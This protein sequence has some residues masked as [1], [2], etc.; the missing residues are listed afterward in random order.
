MSGN[1]ESRSDAPSILRARGVVLYPDR[2]PTIRTT[3]E[4]WREIEVSESEYLALLRQGLIFDGTPP[5]PPPPSFSDEQYDELDDPESEAASRLV[6]AVLD[7]LDVDGEGLVTAAKNAVLDEV[8]DEIDAASAAA[9]AAET[10]AAAALAASA[11]AIP[12]TPEGRQA[13]A[14]SSEV[15]VTTV[16]TAAETLD[17]ARRPLDIWPAF[18]LLGGV[19]GSWDAT[20]Y[21]KFIAGVEAFMAPAVNSGDAVRAVIGTSYNSKDLITFTAGNPDAPHILIC[22]GMHPIE[23]V[24]HFSTMR[25]FQ[26]FVYSQHPA[27]VALRNRARVTWVPCANPSGYRYERKSASGVDLNR[28]F[29]FNWE[30]YDATDPASVNYKGATSASEPEVQALMTLVD[31]GAFGLVIDCH[32]VAEADTLDFAVA[33]AGVW[34]DSNRAL[35]L[36]VMEKWGTMYND[37][38]LVQGELGGWG[39]DP[40]FKHWATRKMRFEQERTGA[41]ALTVETS[42]RLY[43]ST[44]DSTSRA[45]IRAYCGYLTLLIADWI[46]SAYVPPTPKPLSIWATTY[47]TPSPSELAIAAGGQWITSGTLAAFG[48]QSATGA[49]D[50]PSGERRKYIDFPVRGERGGLITVTATGYIVAA[51]DM[52]DPSQVEIYLSCAP[53]PIVGGDAPVDGA[54]LRRLRVDGSATGWAMNGTEFTTQILVPIGS[55]P[56]NNLYRAQ[57]HFRRSAGTG[58]MQVRRASMKIEFDPYSAV[59]IQPRVNRL[60]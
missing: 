53:T 51:P 29:P 46:D 27:M 5:P 13:L 15:K 37:G 14:T 21:D 16:A 58:K 6:A 50:W 25:F 44:A 17:P 30:L 20:T 55:F 11:N 48:W 9:A 41:L 12:N 35:P 8:G 22:G 59:N 45:A 31:E 47:A 3:I 52:V 43:G 24:A 54:S 49:A 18:T 19:E 57:L 42:D 56:D 34:M 7:S 38:T 33:P 23:K 26:Q 36:S 40:N 60:S 32:N 28:N 39:G 10:S 4:P 2:M 1:P